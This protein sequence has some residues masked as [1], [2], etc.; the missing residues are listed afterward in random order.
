M[1][2]CDLLNTVLKLSLLQDGPSG[3]TE[4]ATARYDIAQ[5]ISAMSTGYIFKDLYT[6]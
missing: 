4:L 1:G 5:C 2:T 6:G 3:S